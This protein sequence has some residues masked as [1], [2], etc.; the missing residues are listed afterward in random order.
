LQPALP[1]LAPQ[2]FSARPVPRTAAG[3]QPRLRPHTSTITWSSRSPRSLAVPRIRRGAWAGAGRTLA[4][5]EQLPRPFPPPVEARC[6]LSARLDAVLEQAQR[7]G[8]AKRFRCAPELVTSFFQ[9]SAETLQELDVLLMAC[10]DRLGYRTD[11]RSFGHVLRMSQHLE[12]ETS[13]NEGTSSRSHH[14]RNEKGRPSPCRAQNARDLATLEQ[15]V[16]PQSPTSTSRLETR[17]R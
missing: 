11:R 9:F 17:R 15:L 6:V 4:W 5:V 14:E 16:K 13:G 3:E 8:R 7:P 12:R 10:L 1:L 2:K